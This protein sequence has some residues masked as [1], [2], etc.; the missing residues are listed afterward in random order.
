MK[1]DEVQHLIDI[2]ESIAGYSAQ[3]EGAVLRDWASI[4]DEVRKLDPQHFPAASRA[5]FIRMQRDIVNDQH[6]NMMDPVKR[7]K[8]TSTVAQLK[9]Y[10]LENSVVGPVSELDMLQNLRPEAASVRSRD[11]AKM[12]GVLERAKMLARRCFGDGSH[13]ITDIDAISWSPSIIMPNTDFVKPFE[14][15]RTRFLNLIDVM[16]EEQKLSE[17]HKVGATGGPQPIVSSKVF[18]VH[19]HDTE[20]KASVARLLSKLDLE[21]IILHEQANQGRTLIEKFEKHADVG[22][23]IVLVSPSGRSRN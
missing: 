4:I 13:Y 1:R 9:D 18:I 3:Q 2:A 7:G 20:M 5:Q 19:G 22:F 23:A 10:L 16:L 17:L 8:I 14:N 6:P 11:H 21:P 12:H 15:G